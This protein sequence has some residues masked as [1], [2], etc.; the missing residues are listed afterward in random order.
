MGGGVAALIDTNLGD[1]QLVFALT[2]V[3][4]LTG[5]IVTERTI[6]PRRDAGRQRVRVTFNPSGLVMLAT[7]TQGMHSLFT[8]RF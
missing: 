5:M 4:A 2:T 3:G 7:G 8:V 6:D 1:P